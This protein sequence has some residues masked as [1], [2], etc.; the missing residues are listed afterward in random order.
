VSMY[1][2]DS[3]V[4]LYIL[5]RRW[6]TAFVLICKEASFWRSSRVLGF[7]LRCLINFNGFDKLVLFYIE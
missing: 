7:N 5:R 4:A 3:S 1:R 6:A 2:V